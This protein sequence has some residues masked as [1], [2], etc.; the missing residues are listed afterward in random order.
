M[1]IDAIHHVNLRAPADELKTLRDFYCAV[2]GLTEGPRPPFRSAGYWLYADGH[3][4][5]HLSEMRSGETLVEVSQRQSAFDHV[6]FRCTDL[7]GTLARLKERGI[8]HL[9]EKV[10]LVRQ[11]QVFFEDPSGI[12]VELNFPW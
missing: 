1:P 9:L 7:E 10:P 8:R 11:T 12:G 5:V 4:I 6:A 3:P 2:L